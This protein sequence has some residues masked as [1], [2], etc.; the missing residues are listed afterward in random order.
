MIELERQAVKEY[1]RESRTGFWK[2]E[3]A[4]GGIRMYA[5]ATMQEL[6]GVSS[7]ITPEDCYAFF[8]AHIHPEDM[9]LVKAYQ[10]EL[11]RGEA[12]IVYR[13]LHPESGEMYVRCGGRRI[14]P[15]SEIVTIAGY[16]REY[17]DVFRLEDAN[18]S[19][20]QLMQRNRDLQQVQNRTAVYN[21]SII[22]RA[23]CGIVSY[24]LPN[25]DKLYMNQEAMRVYGIR[26][27]ST[28]LES[29][30]SL[31]PHVVYSSAADLQTLRGLRTADGSVDYECT[32]F[33]EDGTASSLLAHTEVI[34]TPEGERAVYTTFL[35]ISENES[36]KNEKHILDTL[37]QDFISFSYLSF[38]KETVTVLKSD[39]ETARFLKKGSTIVGF[40]DYR[41]ELREC[42]AQCIEQNSAP[43]FVDMLSPEHLRTYLLRNKRLAYRFC[44]VTTQ[45]ELHYLEATGALTGE[46]G[47]GAVVGFRLIDNIIAQEEQKKAQLQQV[48]AK[49]E[50]QIHTIGGLSNAYFAV[51]R[52]DLRAGTCNA[53]KN[54]PFFAQAVG[55][56]L[57]ADDVTNAFI[58]LCVRPEDQEKMRVFTD[59]TRLHTLLEKNDLVV[60]E[61]HGMLQPWEWCR[62]SWIAASRDENGAVTTV[63]FAVEDISEIVAEQRQREQEHRL[64]DEQT[65]VI[66]GLSREFSTIWLVTQDG[67][68]SVKYRDTESDSVAREPMF[69]ASASMDYTAGMQAYITH[70]VSEESQEEFSRKTQYEVVLHE[71]RQQPIYS[72]I[73]KR[74]YQGAEEY[75]QMSFTA[76]GSNDSNDFIV[77][78]KNVNDIVLAEREKNAA[79]TE[80][81]AAAEYANHAKT[82]FLNNMSHDIRT[83]MNAIIGFTSL[84]ASHIDNKEKVQEYLRKIGTSS[85]HLL[86]LI[87][88]V[89]DMSR[90]E[91]GKVKIEEKPLHLPD[92]LHDIRTII[93]PTI[94]SKQLDF[95]ID[96]V[97][98]VDEDVYADKLRL[99]QILL[100]ILG[101]GVK[102]NKTGGMISLRV[103][104]EHKAPSGCAR[105][106]FVIRD[107]G[108]GIS[109]EFQE[110]IFESFS[111]AETATV[112]GIQGTG[113]GLAI[114]KKIVDMMGGT[115]SLK[116]E[117]GVGS[118][119]DVCLT[120]RLTGERRVYQKVESLQGLRVLVAD[121]DTDTCL[122]VSSML[123]EIGMRSEWTVSGKEAV[124]RAKHAM[125]M[126]D[127]FYA[128]IIDWLMPDM[129][130]IE[131]VR[132]IRKVI[133][134]E[135]P[136]IILTAYDWSDVEEEAREA[137]VTAFCEKPLFMSELR[138]IL[139]QPVPVCPL[140]PE[141]QTASPK[142]KRILLVEDN[143][144]NQEIAVEIL[145]EAGFAVEVAADGSIAVEKMRV[146]KPGQYDLILMDIQMPI[147]N[148]YEATRQ[149]RAMDS[150]CCKEIPILAMTANAF[151]EDR[152]DAI[153]A[154]MNGHLA[155]PIDLK[156]L[157]KTLSEI[158]R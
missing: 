121:D 45:G 21:R 97:D 77:G 13:Y 88:D 31:M 147:L 12:D 28:A 143:A 54:I 1:I 6:L 17:S 38:E 79:L 23:A 52:V 27:L 86:S 129:N 125:E 59:R 3:L 5:D 20:R 55:N 90:I 131:T 35:D 139:S 118:E 148:G 153:A 96:T 98:V 15:E 144:L 124:I 122:S 94:S 135:K 157:L 110:H 81:L 140:E 67:R 116:S 39:A 126:G 100:N 127:E 76:A 84:A 74:H 87:N 8:I 61:F 11:L 113:L 83:P 80:A 29:L 24:T 62:A 102:F 57:S 107:T 47:T 78:F 85:E 141:Q 154:G 106:H 145:R 103:R 9:P 2:M 137:G 99:T 82:Q 25:R 123:T 66:S 149:I 69:S 117:E 46:N 109:K 34:T 41:E 115:I 43:D 112:S 136:I 53:L 51:Y 4:E 105:Y 68:S 32:V 63:L 119:F 111:R 133:G 50:E 33:R 65:R 120:F 44:M 142:G 138:D 72:V 151:E 101:N 73:Y 95:L 75:F 37:C 108:I 60:E 71:L 48:N 152:Q 134:E 26:D 114:T 91:S 128:Y 7:D 92:L 18:Q 158:L 16:H 40:A 36:L 104:Q 42:F 130:G 155:K 146:A 14:A 10:E 70:Y 89:L 30:G 132:R 19:A 64:L 49:L 22:D 156:A 56:C 58:A 150:P 93:Q